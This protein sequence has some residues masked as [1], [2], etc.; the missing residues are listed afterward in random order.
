MLRVC[1]GWLMIDGIS[2]IGPVEHLLALQFHHL[3]GFRLYTYT[4]DAVIKWSTHQGKEH[5]VFS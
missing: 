3:A 5:P 1:Y 2:P 4:H